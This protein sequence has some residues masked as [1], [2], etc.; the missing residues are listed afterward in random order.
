MANISPPVPGM[1]VVDPNVFTPQRHPGP[2]VPYILDQSAVPRILPSS[3]SS[4]ATG[5]ITLTTALPYQPS[6]VVY[7]YLP[8]GV[9]TGGSA[10]TGAGMYPVIFS[11]TTVAQIQ[12]TGIVTANGAYTQVTTAVTMATLTI[13]G[14]A[15]GANGTLR[16]DAEW[17]WPNNANTKTITHALAGT[18]MF[19]G[20]NGSY[21]TTNTNGRAS[22]R[23]RNRGA[24]NQN[25][26]LQFTNA[27]QN[28]NPVYST[29]DTSVN[30]NL[31][32]TGQLAV[33]TDYII[34]EGYTVEVLPEA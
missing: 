28:G 31:T 3:G 24:Q 34:L 20:I 6:G 23:I 13:P 11:S 15:M 27:S 1:P 16:F 8:A 25:T 22:A 21:P 2:F 7:I 4:N 9:V 17:A 18:V 10:G 33:A 30:Q 32:F 29:I 14:G 26:S 5:Q 19:Y 12:G